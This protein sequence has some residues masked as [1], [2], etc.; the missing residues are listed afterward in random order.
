VRDED[1]TRRA[2]N[3]PKPTMAQFNLESLRR[4]I[5]RETIEKET[6]NI[7]L[8]NAALKMIFYSRI[9]LTKAQRGKTSEQSSSGRVLSLPIN[10]STI[11]QDHEDV[12]LRLMG[13]MSLRGSRSQ[14]LEN[15]TLRNQITLHEEQSRGNIG[16][17][18][19][20]NATSTTTVDLFNLEFYRR[21]PQLSRDQIVQRIIESL[22]DPHGLLNSEQVRKAIQYGTARETLY[23]EL[24]HRAKSQSY[25]IWCVLESVDCLTYRV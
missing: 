13:Q 2:S 15:S 17:D 5:Q 20:V 14:H 12:L 21:T 22:A 24:E 6:E 9:L 23:G 4:K 25:Q 10:G 18:S 8:W 11:T 16:G 19:N 7:G 3:S 1:S